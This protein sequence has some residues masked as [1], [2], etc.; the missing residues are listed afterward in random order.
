MG[1]SAAQHTHQTGLDKKNKT[2]IM[3]FVLAHAHSRSCESV[4]Q[5]SCGQTHMSIPQCYD[6]A[7]KSRTCS[8]RMRKEFCAKYDMSCSTKLEIS[9]GANYGGGAR[10]LQC[11]KSFMLH[12]AK[13][14]RQFCAYNNRS[15]RN[16]RQHT[17]ETTFVQRIQLGCHRTA[18]RHVA[19]CRSCI[20]MLAR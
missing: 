20:N 11:A 16:R 7:K 4:L 17:C 19:G 8:Q 15:L 3:L 6:C 5:A 14:S 1:D 12:C 18:I 2:K 9:C 10:C 13:E